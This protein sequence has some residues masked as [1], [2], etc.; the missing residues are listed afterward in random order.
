[1]GSEKKSLLKYR[2]FPKKDTPVNK[3]IE[4]NSPSPPLVTLQ[5][6]LGNNVFGGILQTKL[7]VNEPGDIYEK[8]AD[9]VADEVVNSTTPS[10]QQQPMEEEKDTLQ[11]KYSACEKEEELQM[12]AES[13]QVAGNASPEVSQ[14]IQNAGGGNRLSSSVNSEMSQKMGADFSNVNIHTSSEAV[15]LNQSLGARAFT[16]G[17]D[18]FFNSGEYNPDGREGK[19]LLAHELVH[20]LQQRGT[21]RREEIENENISENTFQEFVDELNLRH[22]SAAELLTKGGSHH[23]SEHPGYGLNTDPPRNLWMNIVQTIE[24]LDAFRESI[25]KAITITSAYRSPEYNATLEGAAANSQHTY[26]RAIDFQVRGMNPSEYGEEMYKLRDSDNFRG[27]IGI[28]DS[29][30]H[31]DTRGINKDFGSNNHRRN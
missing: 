18:I 31:V 9:R 10:I 5:R 12:K 23:D 21:I 6:T 17:K 16:H 20:T 28:Y 1:M 30:V 25:G 27:G 29:F 24:L 4:S 26:F 15:R 2:S 11:R 7:K 3:K 13:G 19:R 22:F 14:K 8:E